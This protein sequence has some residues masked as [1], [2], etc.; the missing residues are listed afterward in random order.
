MK[1]ELEYQQKTSRA[2]EDLRGQLEESEANGTNLLAKVS[3]LTQSLSDADRE[4]RS[5][6]TKLAAS[7][8]AEANLKA[9]G[10]AMKGNAARNWTGQSELMHAAHAKEDLY[11]DLTGLLVQSMKRENDEDVF[12]C[13]QTGRNGSESTIKNLRGESITN[14]ETALH[15]KLALG[16]GEESDRYEDM[17]FTYKPQLQSDRDGDLMEVL[18]DYLQGVIS[19]SRSQAS[20]FYSRVI[21]SLTERKTE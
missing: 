6:T 21:K 19:F 4:I 15:F 8:S 7:R 9:P 10:S 17:Q 11:G 20:K 16:P 2:T 5:L 13:I 18:P 14:K 1:K 3:D 12:D